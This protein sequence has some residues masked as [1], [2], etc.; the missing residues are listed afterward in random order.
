[1]IDAHVH[2][3]PRNVE[4]SVKHMIENME[5][6]GVEKALVFPELGGCF[7]NNAVELA[8]ERYPNR[9]IGICTV[10]SFD[11]GAPAELERCLKK[12]FRGLKLHPFLQGLN[13]SSHLNDQLFELVQEYKGI[14]IAHGTADLY[15]CPLEFDRMARRFPK[16][17][18]I[19]AHCG[20]FWE[21][22]QAVELALENPNLFLETSRVPEYE[23][24]KMIERAGCE[25]VIW[26]SDTPY[27][28]LEQEI[29]KMRRVLKEEEKERILGGTIKRL[30]AI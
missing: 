11:E 26:G 25:K 30:L 6:N 10:N 18:L 12:G 27:C 9:I 4:V 1:M 22:E 13:L 19:M 7:T 14:V 17:P 15:N 20:Y 16:V 3:G 2:I 23:T 24:G 8:M 21:W 5:Q 28:N 29:H